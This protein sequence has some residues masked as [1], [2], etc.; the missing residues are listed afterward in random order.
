VW[1]AHFVAD[2]P[3][4]VPVT[5]FRKKTELCEVMTKF[6]DKYFLADRT[7]YDRLL[8]SSCRPSVCLSVTLYI[9]A[10]MQGWCTGLNVVLACSQ[11][12]SSYFSVQTL[13]L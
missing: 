12:A 13:L 8:A 7:Q 9:V 11:P 10:L 5:G 1:W 6:G 4:H 2:L 3:L